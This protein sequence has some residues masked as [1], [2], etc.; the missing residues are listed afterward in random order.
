MHP[1]CTFLPGYTIIVARRGARDVR[2]TFAEGPALNPPPNLAGGFFFGAATRPSQIALQPRRHSP[3]KASVGYVA[4]MTRLG[5]GRDMSCHVVLLQALAV[6]AKSSPQRHR[7]PFKGG[8]LG[9]ETQ[10]RTK[11]GTPDTRPY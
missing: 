8:A 11:R 2:P 3:K 1:P 9:V 5:F 4:M 6:C 10:C 7:P